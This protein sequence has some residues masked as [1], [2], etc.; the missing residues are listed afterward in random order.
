M[1]SISIHTQAILIYNK[2]MYYGFI[3]NLAKNL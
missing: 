1:Q 3:Y 2:S